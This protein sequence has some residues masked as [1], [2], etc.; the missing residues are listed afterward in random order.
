MASSRS[1]RFKISALLVI[2]LLSLAALWLFGASV[3]TRESVNLLAVASLYADIGKPGEDLAVALQGEH[4]SSAEYL[5]SRSPQAQNALAR[6]RQAADRFKEGMR[7]VAGSERTRSE[8]S[9]PEMRAAF[10]GVMTALG[11]LDATRAAVD[12]GAIDPVTLTRDFSLV[13]DAMQ[14][15][16]ITMSATN[17]VR[18]Y[19]QS[20]ALTSMGYSKDHFSRERAL[21]AGALAARRPLTPAEMRL[22]S[23]LAATRRFLFTQGLP[24]LD[25]SVGDPFERLASS[26]PYVRF[27]ALEDRVLA[28]PGSGVTHAMWRSVADQV[29]DSFQAAVT[30]GGDA[31]AASAA[32]AAMATFVRAGLAGAVGLLAVIASLIVSFRVGRGLTREL[33]ELRSAATDLA[34][35]RLPR[36]IERLRRGEEVDLDTEAPPLALR[37]TTTEIRDVSAAFGSVQRTAVAVAVEQAGL[38]DAVGKAF[39]N[40]AR[41][42]QS[43][44]QRQL[45]LLDGM[46]RRVD[47][48]E[49]LRDLFRVDHLTTRMRRHAEGLVIL[50]GESPGRTFRRPVPVMDAL[51]AA[52]G[53]VE[54]YTRVRV[55]PMPDATIAGSAVADVVHLCAELV[56]NATAF[57]PPNT[58]ISVRGELVAKGFAVEIEDRGLGMS[59]AERDALNEK[60]SRPPEFDP[61]ETE[62]L[63][64]FVIGRL[65]ARHGIRVELCVSP[66]GGTTAIVL[67]PD[68]LVTP[69][70]A[71]DEPP[72]QPARVAR[73][74][75]HPDPDAP[76]AAS[77]PASR[78]RRPAAGS[79]P[80]R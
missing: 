58:E 76:P 12:R 19:Q 69:G 35:V 78:P 23:E 36:V 72:S 40:L 11:H 77:G 32:P 16:V 42:S 65:A 57:S 29:E 59:D 64:L 48:P 53:E 71:E 15:L 51:R 13:P 2:P 54:D 21:V 7:R 79:A 14:K 26:L 62:R 74:R 60:L 6:Q 70:A 39:R 55:H 17:D 33:G 9:T 67:I 49:T 18:L 25:P 73:P 45:K 20:R 34:T 3:T 37:A 46:Q 24:E 75:R 52:V 80:A 63:G 68:T 56:E 1:V 30:T 5:G 28:G 50:S 43:L 47:E 31:L 22:L 61:A 4:L 41:R 44:L 27:T 8:L 38:R 66:Y 10:D